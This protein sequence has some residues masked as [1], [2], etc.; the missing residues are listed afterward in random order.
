METKHQKVKFSDYL[1]VSYKWKKLL[2]INLLIITI[3]ST[4]YSF[5]IPEQFKATS[6]VMVSTNT[7]QGMGGIT[8]LLSGDMLSMSSQ[9]LGGTNPSFDLVFG[10]LGSRTSLTTI[11]NR[12]N[13]IEYYGIDDNNMD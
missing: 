2:I 11:I 9:L 3:L 5:L 8:S 13:L 12:Y 1:S 6:I 4:V 10:I 7:Q